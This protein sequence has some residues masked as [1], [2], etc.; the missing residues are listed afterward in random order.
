M[1]KRVAQ[2]GVFG[3]VAIIGGRF[4]VKFLEKPVTEL[5]SRLRGDAPDCDAVSE[6]V[7]SPRSPHAR[8][9]NSLVEEPKS[10]VLGVTGDGK[11]GS[12]FSVVHCGD[13]IF[14]WQRATP[15][16]NKETGEDTSVYDDIPDASGDSYTCQLEDAGKLLRV[17]YQ[18]PEDPALHCLYLNGGMPV[19]KD[20]ELVQS[21]KAVPLVMYDVEL[22][23]HDATISGHQLVLCPKFILLKSPERL[24]CQ[25]KF[26]TWPQSVNLCAHEQ[27]AV[28]VIERSS[29]PEAIEVQFS[30]RMERDQA[31]YLWHAYYTACQTKAAKGG[32]FRRSRPMPIAKPTPT[33]FSSIPQSSEDMGE[34][35]VLP[36]G[37]QASSGDTPMININVVA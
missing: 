10:E 33:R 37:K 11:V 14:L 22:C 6:G 24:L 9:H 31:V 19:E 3:A 30:G 36:P 4:A 15:Q 5:L 2:V 17:I 27:R 35:L 28:F 32:F 8:R 21:I 7:T 29:R 25:E 16:M 26:K 18:R 12:T 20:A 13:F 23:S 1:V 34:G